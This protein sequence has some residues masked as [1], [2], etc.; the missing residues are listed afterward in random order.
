MGELSLASMS[1]PTV[2]FGK[3]TME[4]GDK[5]LELGK[6]GLEMSKK[7]LG[8]SR[9]GLEKGKKGIEAIQAPEVRKGMGKS[10]DMGKQGYKKAKAKAKKGKRVVGIKRDKRITGDTLEANKNGE[11]A[12]HNLLMTATT[13]KKA[14]IVMGQEASFRLANLLIWGMR[15]FESVGIQEHNLTGHHARF[16]FQPNL[17]LLAAVATRTRR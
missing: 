7:G 12:V 17:R 3:Q 16:F 9:Q 6:Q 2:E 1:I 14:M 4:I 13:M 5:T 10:A 15:T 8:M 11:K